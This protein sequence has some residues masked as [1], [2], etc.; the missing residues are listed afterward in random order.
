MFI[1]NLEAVG[2]VNNISDADAK[3]LEVF[4]DHIICFRVNAFR[5]GVFNT[6]I[7]LSAV[8]SDIVVV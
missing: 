3:P 8:F 1:V 2:L 7:E 6:V 4:G 5:V